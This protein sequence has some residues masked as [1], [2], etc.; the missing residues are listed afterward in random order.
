MTRKRK[1]FERIKNNP[2]NVSF[3][4]IEG[5]LLARGFVESRPASGSS[6]CTFSK[7]I[8]TITIPFARPIK[9]IYVKHVIAIIEM[10][11]DKEYG[12]KS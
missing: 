7:G 4:K 5:L 6:H 12:K 2:K 10:S 11:E 9:E 3:E 1:E 8:Y